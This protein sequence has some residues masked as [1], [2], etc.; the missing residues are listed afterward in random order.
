MN[1]AKNYIIISSILIL[2]GIITNYYLIFSSKTI[3]DVFFIPAF[4]L[5][6]TALFLKKSNHEK[7]K[8]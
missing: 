7:N 8:Y 5:N 3:V 6:V 1:K 2:I 4:I